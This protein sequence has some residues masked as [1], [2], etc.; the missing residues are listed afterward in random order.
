MASAKVQRG[1]FL[2]LL[3]PFR[4]IWTGRNEKYTSVFIIYCRSH[5]KTCCRINK[6]R[7][8]AKTNGVSCKKAHEFRAIRRGIRETY[9]H[10]SKPSLP[11]P[12]FHGW[13]ICTSPHPD[14]P[15]ILHRNGP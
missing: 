2:S 3:A 14:K 15:G 6:I 5:A 9:G 10:L 8:S 11:A 1:Y 12:D 13:K 7:R 4:R